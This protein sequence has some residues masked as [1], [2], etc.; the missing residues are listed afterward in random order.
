VDPLQISNIFDNHNFDVSMYWIIAAL[1]L[2]N[3]E[4]ATPLDPCRGVLLDT[5]LAFKVCLTLTLVLAKGPDLDSGFEIFSVCAFSVGFSDS[6]EL[7][8]SSIV[9][10][11]DCSASS[12]SFSGFFSF[13]ISAGADPE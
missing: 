9:S 3:I 2:S 1:K 5:G 12:I 7:K 6:E 13:A 4:T 10:V 11:K 8:Y